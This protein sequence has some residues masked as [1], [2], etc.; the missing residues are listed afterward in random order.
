MTVAYI[1]LPSSVVAGMFF[2]VL[3]CVA[4]EEAMSKLKLKITLHSRFIVIFHMVL[5]V[6]LCEINVRVGVT[7]LLFTLT[8][9]L[10]E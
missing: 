1:R 2:F 6:A 4:R 9:W 10:F 5:C 7:S 8:V 3:L